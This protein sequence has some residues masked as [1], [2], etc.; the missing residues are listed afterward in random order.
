MEI[1]CPKCTFSRTVNEEKVPP[2]AEVATCP[3][4]GEKFRFRTVGLKTPPAPA[5]TPRPPRPEASTPPPLREG[6]PVAAPP[7]APSQTPPLNDADDQPRTPPRPTAPYH[8]PQGDV[9]ES[10][11]DMGRDE[12]GSRGN[13]RPDFDHEPFAEEDVPWE[14]LDVYGFFPGLVQTIKRVMLQPAS[15]FGTMPVGGGLLRP[16]AF[17]VLVGMVS[18]IAQYVF[19]ILGMQFMFGVTDTDIPGEAYGLMGA[20]SAGM[21]LIYPLVMAAGLFVGAGIQHVLLLLF[22]AGSR[23][24]EATFRVAAYASAPFILGVIPLLGNV[25][26]GIWGLVLIVI[27][28]KYVHDT[29]YGRVLAAIFAPLL[30]LVFLGILAAVMLG[31]MLS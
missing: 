7:Q 2:T 20:M 29:T 26:G 25:V 13:H 4:C 30:A 10:L 21:L 22:K 16:L 9:F 12:R 15:F 14:R 23:G 6:K 3:K 1:K 18:F 24:F 28:L 31:A 19:Q 8:V 27:G 17:Y 5:T 11:D